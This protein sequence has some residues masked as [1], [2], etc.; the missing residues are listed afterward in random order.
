VTQILY[1]P[2]FDGSYGY[3]NN[4]RRAALTFGDFEFVCSNTA[5]TRAVDNCTYNYIF[6]VP[7]ALHTGDLNST[8]YTGPTQPQNPYAKAAV[9]LQRWVSSFAVEG[10]PVAKGTEVY[11]EYGRDG[12]VQT[13]DLT[14]VGREV[15][16]AVAKRCDFWFGETYK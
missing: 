9:D 3:K 4:T 13:L 15:D 14:G 16:P 5:L 6:A 1:P 11:G 7:L 8:F 12:M 2:I 10:R